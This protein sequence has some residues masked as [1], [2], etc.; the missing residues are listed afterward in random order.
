MIA[1]DEVSVL[2]VDD[3]APFRLAARAVL[4]RAAGFELVGEAA[5]GEEAIDKVAELRPALVLM[6]INM[7]GINGIE[8]TRRLL[9]R[10]PE[11]VVFLCSTYQ[12]DDLPAEATDSGAAAYVNKEELGPDLLRRLWDEP[13]GL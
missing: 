6:D 2:V 7:P 12:R 8:A 9:A 10:A 1:T 13:P 5:T 11:T 4:R 3:Q